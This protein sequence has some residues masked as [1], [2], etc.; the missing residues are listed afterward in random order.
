MNRTYNFYCDESCHLEH[1]HKKYMFLGAVSS[2]YPEVRQHTLRINELKASHNFYAEIKWSHVS[3]SKILFYLD[4]IDYFFTSTLKFRTLGIDKA[5]FRS[6]TCRDY[7]DFYYKMYYQLL[8]YKVDTLDHY[9]VYLDIKDSLSAVK[10]RNLKDILNTRF[11]VFR[12]VQ[13]IRSEEST[14]MQLSDFLMGAISYNANEGPATNPAKALIVERIIGHLNG[15]SL[16]ETNLSEKFNIIFLDSRQYADQ[17][18]EK[19]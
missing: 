12:T 17:P 3:M 4:L 7:D 16:S 11:G 6:E 2:P 1:D 19:I 10:V 5:L 15:N 9:N 14:L 13:N 18:S 8:N